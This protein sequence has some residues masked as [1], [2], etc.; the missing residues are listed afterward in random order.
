MEKQKIQTP[1]A[2]FIELSQILDV[3]IKFEP[4]PSNDQKVSPVIDVA[5]VLSKF[6][7]LMVYVGWS[8]PVNCMPPYNRVHADIEYWKKSFS[9]MD[10]PQSVQA[11][12]T[13]PDT[14]PT[15]ES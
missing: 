4:D 12:E 11:P 1:E 2:I 10:K 9:L 15:T 3:E 14:N 7:A 8:V 13:A 6:M 5:S